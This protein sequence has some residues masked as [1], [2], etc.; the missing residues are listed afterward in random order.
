MRDTQLILR[1]AD[2]YISPIP[3]IELERLGGR[4]D[5]LLEDSSEETVER[6]IA[7]RSEVDPLAG[8]SIFFGGRLSDNS[9][10]NERNYLKSELCAE[11]SSKCPDDEAEGFIWN[12]VWRVALRSNIKEQVGLFR[13][14][15]SQKKGRVGFELVIFPEYRH[16]GYARQLIAK[17]TSYAF[18]KNDVYYLYTNVPGCEDPEEYERI[19][20]R[21]GFRTDEELNDPFA[22]D[23]LIDDEEIINHRVPDMLIK[24][25]GV[26]SYS[27][28][29]VMVGLCIGMVISI[30][31][32]RMLE[33]LAGGL[34]FSTVLGAIMDH[35]EIKH[36]RLILSGE[37]ENSPES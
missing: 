1:T 17:M 23:R 11:L 12:T 29:Y 18:D 36:R 3:S 30:F 35:F 7:L 37:D 13:F 6:S 22:A 26:T 8:D 2:L 10:L 5:S 25:S 16:M 9:D 19:L 27:A 20:R 14:K 24:E 31:S 21:S 32:N 28:A 33:G 15:G 34:I 4:D